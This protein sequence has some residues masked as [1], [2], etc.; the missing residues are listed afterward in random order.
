[1][2]LLHIITQA[3]LML[4]IWTPAAWAGPAAGALL[5][6]FAKKFI[7]NMIVSAITSKIF[8]KKKKGQ[9]GGAGSQV[10]VNKQSNNES[11]PVQ[12]GRRRIGGV[13]VFVGT[14]DG[15]GA[16]G[17]NHLNIVLSLCEGEMGDLKQL[18][19]NDTL[20][21]D[22]TCAHGETIAHAD[23]DSNADHTPVVPD[24]QAD[25]KIENKYEKYFLV[26]YMS[27]TD[28]QAAADEATSS[29][30]TDWTSAHQLK[31]IAYLYCKLK[32]D[33]EAYEGGVPTITAV[34]DGKKI[35]SV[36]DL[37]AAKTA[38]ANQN[39]ADVIHDY[40]TNDRYGKGLADADIDIASFQSAK[41]Y[42]STRYEINGILDTGE[43]L[44]Q[45]IERLTMACNAMLVFHNGVYKLKIKGNE[46]AAT[47]TF[48][49]ENILSDVTVSLTDIKA[50]LNKITIDFANRDSDV[51]YNDDV[52]I[53]DDATY[54]TQDNDTVLEQTI[55]MP[56]IT[57]QTLIESMGDFFMDESRDKM[58]IEFEAAHTEFGVEAGEIINVTLDDYGFTNKQFRVVQTEL[59]PENTISIIGQEYTAGIHI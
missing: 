11:I 13:R 23:I 31:G 49:T 30:D 3:F 41:T 25:P 18:Y 53:R 48:T 51:N 58:M 9:T 16:E 55:E 35:R 39:P 43:T 46:S 36:A 22:G 27:G 32:F 26:Q 12:Y 33:A 14:S 8:G 42:A 38:G 15:A 29:I 10:M 5:A 17:T 7:I 6:G 28:T 56:M 54:L 34:I 20:V 37:S 45:N 1:M 40:L 47:R 52:V 50:R 24:D 59:T 4:L 21:F 57:D 19:F 2:K 44:M